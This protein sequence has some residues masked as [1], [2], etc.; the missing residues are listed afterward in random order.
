L[1]SSFEDIIYWLPV[2]VV[3]SAEESAP[4]AV[5]PLVA[6]PPEQPVNAVAPIIRARAA[7]EIFLVVFFI[8]YLLYG[9]SL[10]LNY[11]IIITNFLLSFNY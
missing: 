9:L 10:P 6:V 2:A 8:I 3:L 5:P 7:A 11:L 1:T 4:F